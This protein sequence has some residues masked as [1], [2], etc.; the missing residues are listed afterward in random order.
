MW[1]DVRLQVD[2]EVEMAYDLLRLIRREISKG[3]KGNIKFRGVLLGLKD[4]MMISDNCC[5]DKGKAKMI[6]LEK[7][8]K[9]KDQIMIDEEV[10]RNLEAQMQAE[11]EEEERLAR[12][13]E[14]EANTALI[15]S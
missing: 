15:E 3:Y 13:K 8:L 6:K 2:Y 1:N 10:A 7:P 14:E 11:L 4:F 12:Q 5:S 9:M